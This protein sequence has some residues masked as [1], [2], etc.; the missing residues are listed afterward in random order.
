MGESGAPSSRL[1]ASRGPPEGAKF[2]R[3]PSNLRIRRV[4][5]GESAPGVSPGPSGGARFPARGPR[6]GSRTGPRAGPRGDPKRRDPK[7]RKDRG[8]R[9]EVESFDPAEELPDGMVL[10]LMRL[11]SDEWAQKA[12]EPVY[13]SGDVITEL[14]DA[15]RRI[16]AGQP[17]K[18]KTIATRI[19]EEKKQ[20]GELV[21]PPQW[22]QWQEKGAVVFIPSEAGGNQALVPSQLQ[23][24]PENL[25]GMMASRGSTFELV[26]KQANELV[27]R[28]PYEVSEL[29]LK[30]GG[31][32]EDKL[33][34]TVTRGLQT[35]PTYLSTSQEKFL[36]KVSQ[37]MRI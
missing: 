34:G 36:E 11:Q 16:V 22:R 2:V 23:T 28:G 19:L 32:R 17:A 33:V 20:A 31:K 12:Y 27:G 13:S 26:E 4:S 6:A 21:K 15:G 29:G 18:E 7:D 10:Q 5:P 24:A 37:V 9:R 30:E 14:L 25:M 35:N 3:A 8:G 1:V